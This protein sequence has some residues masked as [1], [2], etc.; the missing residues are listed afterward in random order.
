M[1]IMIMIIIMVFAQ[2]SNGFGEASLELYV[3]L[4][5]SLLK[6]C[7]FSMIKQES[8]SGQIA[9][10]IKSCFLLSFYVNLVTAGLQ[11]QN[12]NVTKSWLDVQKFR[13]MVF[14][15]LMSMTPFLLFWREKGS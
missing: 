15:L 4:R 3:S 12:I 8:I 10:C 9:V 5:S 2:R 1:I 6:L 14:E 11:E 13:K 7:T